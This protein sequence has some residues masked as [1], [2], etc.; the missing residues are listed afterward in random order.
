MDK[1]TYNAAY[2]A[3][4][5]EREKAR[6][7]A[8]YHENK[9]K[10]DRSAR[11]RYMRRYYKEHPEKWDATAESKDKKNRRRREKYATDEAYREAHKA[12]AREFGK[13]N[14][15]AKKATRL[16]TYGLT[17]DQFTGMLESQKSVCAICQSTSDRKV[18]FPVVDHCHATGRVRGL[19][20]A[21]CNHGLGKFK[22]SPDLLMRAVEYLIRGSSGAAST[23][24][25]TG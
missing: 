17:M 2:Y 5:K 23:T 13:R 25:R 12:I 19:L 10:M 24:S 15:V 21:N 8:W 14:P 18:I 9:G 16:R 11:S 7:L 3:A 22:D 6:A 4:N 20:C 1:A